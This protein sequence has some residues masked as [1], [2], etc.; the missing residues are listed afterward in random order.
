MMPP[1]SLQSPPVGLHVMENLGLVSAVGI[2]PARWFTWD[3]PSLTEEEAFHNAVRALTTTARKVGANAVMGVKWMHDNDRFVSQ[4]VGTAVILGR[5]P[6]PRL[7][8][9]LNFKFPAFAST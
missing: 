4:V 3:S 1:T 7:D 5:D 8:L 9:E 2:R 6:N